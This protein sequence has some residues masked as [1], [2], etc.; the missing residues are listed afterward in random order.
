MKNK[1]LR[2]HQENVHK[3]DREFLL[4]GITDDDLIH[5]CSLC[6]T[7]FV[8]ET[9]LALHK[10]RIHKKVR[11]TKG[12]SSGAKSSLGNNSSPN[13]KCSSCDQEFDVHAQL[14]KHS[15]KVHKERTSV[16][17]NQEKRFKCKLCYHQFD[18]NCYLDQHQK[19]VHKDE[20]HLFE[21]SFTENDLKISCENCD[22]KFLS[23][24]SKDFHRRYQHKEELK[25]LASVKSDRGENKPIAKTSFSCILCYNK[26]S[27]NGD[28]KKHIGKFHTTEDEVIALEN[29]FVEEAKLSFS[30]NSCD[31]KFLNTAILK[32]HQMY[33]HRAAKGS[34]SQGGTTFCKLCYVRFQ[35]SKALRSHIAKVHKDEM[36]GFSVKLEE[37]ELRHTCDQCN[38]KFWTKNILDHHTKTRHKD[39][40]SKEKSC[41]LC[42]V[43]FKVSDYRRQ[44]VKKIHKTKDELEALNFDSDFVFDVPCDH[45]DKRVYSKRCLAIHTSRLHSSSLPRELSCRLCQVFSKNNS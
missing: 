28:Y 44:H 9:S 42:Q 3:E 11:M 31:K 29:G 12:I 6:P 35:K 38:R 33:T 34:L 18:F 8:S 25:K 15:L 24:N 5:K 30:C 22:K 1:Y 10:E 13:Y 41:N 27:F 45:C 20:L 23:Q 39:L 19:G 40:S 26:F 37:L 7:K 17:A 16:V 14:R 4:S 32:Y 43:N 2:K 21:G 36:H